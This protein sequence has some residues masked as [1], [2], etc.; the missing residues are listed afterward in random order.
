MRIL[1]LAH[2]FAPFNASGAVR[3]VKLA[4]HL[5][6]TGHDVR[7]I[8]GTPHPYPETLATTFPADRV[9]ATPWLRVEAPLDA[10]R[11]QLGHRVGRT[12]AP[13][14]PGGRSRPSLAARG[15]LAY[16]NVLSV[17]DPQIGWLPYAVAAG[18]R[19]IE[20]WRP[21]LIYSTALPFASHMVAARLAKRAGCP[22]VGEFRD[23]FSANPY[24]DVWPWRARLDT[25]IE[26][27]V[28]A[29]ASA[30]VS[31]SPQM[32]SYLADLHAKPAVTVMNGF[33]PAD[34]A[35]APDMTGMFDARRI[36]IVYTGII[37]PG[38]RDPAAL[39]AAL[40]M[41]GETRQAFDVRFYGPPADAVM[42]AARAA[43]VDDVVSVH[44]PVPYL[45]SL[46]L[47]KAADVLLLLLWDSPLEKGV[48]TG[49]LFEYIGAG[50]SILSLG[51]LDGAAAELVRAHDLGLAATDPAIIADWLGARARAKTTG[52]TT[53]PASRPDPVSL[54][55][56][57][58]QF[59]QL[60]RF[61][62]AQGLLSAPQAHG[63]RTVS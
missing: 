24:S 51:C 23:L 38:R 56:R 57:R 16:R 19:L 7:V 37:Y 44:P 9:T 18:R 20:N 61:L 11:R 29:S 49:K 10:L 63:A 62:T 36:A 60:E 8:T 13:A 41:L 4:E 32:T 42:P 22:W 30:V 5:L 17:P 26:R 48:L 12:S 58:A 35:R 59:E 43:G 28:M 15:V 31:V 6:A 2:A 14:S 52:T 50:R 53:P 45:Q 3:A 21:E 55:S 33:D 39:I 25:R 46:G 1:L 27:R 34:F 54:F 47:Q 40:A